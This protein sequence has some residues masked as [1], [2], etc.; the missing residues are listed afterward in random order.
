MIGDE[1][2]SRVV[3]VLSIVVNTLIVVYFSLLHISQ[4]SKASNLLSLVFMFLIC[5]ILF[6]KK[7]KVFIPMN[8]FFLIAF[9]VFVAVSLLW[10][11]TPEN[12]GYWRAFRTVPLLTIMT[13]LLCNYFKSSGQEKVLIWAVYIS[14]FVLSVAMVFYSGGVSNTISLIRDG[15]RLGGLVENENY[16][17]MSIASA[18]V[19]AFFFVIHEKRF[20]D[21]LTFLFFTL[22]TFATGSRTALL[23]LVVGVCLSVLFLLDFSRGHGRRNVTILFV[24]CASIVVFGVLIFTIPSF[25]GI[26][27]RTVSM[28]HSF[29]DRGGSRD[30]STDARMGMVKLGFQAFCNHPFGGVGAGS[31]GL[32]S[33]YGDLHNNYIEVLAS[34][35]IVGF[36]LYYL[37]FVLS[38]IQLF[39]AIK[40]RDRLCFIAVIINVCWLFNQLGMVTYET[41]DSYFYLALLVTLVEVS[42]IADGKTE[43]ESL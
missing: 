25:S 35:G 41:K 7:E 9:A 5:V 29:L 22:M 30:G 13:I 6:L 18:A 38:I 43:K 20:W 15:Y 21:I 27:A 11:Q 1:R 3:S 17:G 37:P 12:G 32:I 16:L 39:P 23:G 24:A 26:K 40:R 19:V 2:R 36:V 4:V 8:L 28:V 31:S 33:D 34:Y 14:G 10:S 42:S